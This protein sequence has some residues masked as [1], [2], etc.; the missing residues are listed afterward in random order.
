MALAL[1][2]FAG[3]PAGVGAAAT[4]GPVSLKTKHEYAKRS[5]R[6]CGKHKRIHFFHRNG[7]IEFKGFLN[8]STGRHF[9]VK[10]E[11][12]R[13]VAHRRFVSI[14][15]KYIGIGKKSG[16]FKVFHKAPR[17]SGGRR[18]AKTTYF[19]ARA[20][21]NGQPSAKTYFAVTR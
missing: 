17:R 19:F 9:P 12:K 14:G 13:C 20:I 16:K 15:A 21:A 3:V 5:A 11:V 10:I 1:T 8:P 2:I 18:H 4:T 7:V 6:F